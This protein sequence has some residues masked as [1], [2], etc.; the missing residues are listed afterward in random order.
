MLNQEIA[1][2]TEKNKKL[3]GQIE[4]IKKDKQEWQEK[5]GKYKKVVENFKST[6]AELS[7]KVANAESN[8]QILQTFEDLLQT[9]REST[10]TYKAELEVLT[11]VCN[12][13]TVEN[14]LLKEERLRRRNQPAAYLL[15]SLRMFEEF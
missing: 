14:Q 15:S 4:E 12:D 2:L 5:E 11:S 1:R 7:K 3:G 8:K 9:Q 6:I 10:T 13:L